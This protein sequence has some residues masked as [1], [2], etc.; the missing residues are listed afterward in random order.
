MSKTPEF[1]ACGCK[2]A[3][4]TKAFALWLCADCG[5]CQRAPRS[6]KAK[7]V[8]CGRAKGT[9]PKGFGCCQVDWSCEASHC[10]DLAHQVSETPEHLDTCRNG[11]CGGCWVPCQG[12]FEPIALGRLPHPEVEY[13]TESCERGNF[14]A[15]DSFVRCVGCLAL[16]VN[17]D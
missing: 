3:G 9:N 5:H 13:L 17:T 4:L 8:G 1:K 14:R 12:A 10:G 16:V 7:C 11:A 15:R 6:A 2:V